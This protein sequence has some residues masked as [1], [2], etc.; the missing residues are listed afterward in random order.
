M[1]ELRNY[2]SEAIG[3]LYT[4]FENHDIGN[5]LLVLP[6]GGGKSLIAAK[7]CKDA[8]QW[9][10]QRV[11]LL[12]HVR[13]LIEQNYQALHSL[14]PE[15]PSGIYCA[16]LKRKQ[17]H[18][19]I[20][21]ASIQ[22]VHKK[23]ELIGWR[24]LIIIDECHLV[25]DTDGTMYRS[26]LEKMR[27]INP[28]VRIIGLSATP[29]RLKTGYL[30][31]GEDAIFTDI[32]FEL[33][34]IRLVNEGYLSPLIGKSAV[35]HV[36]TKDMA[37]IAGE[38][39]SKEMEERF[40][41]PALIAAAVKEIM[42]FGKDRK[43][44]L[45]FCVSI[46]HAKNVA[47]ALTAMEI[48]TESVSQETPMVD[49]DRILSDFKSGKLRA[50]T[51]VSVLTTGFDAPITDLLAILRS[52]MSP[53][54]FVQIAGRGMRLSHGKSNCLVLDFGENLLR[55]G[56]ITHIKPPNDK[57]RKKDDE[58]GV[59]CPTCR[60]VSPIGTERCECGEILK[61]KPCPSCKEISVSS[62]KECLACGHIFSIPREIN[63]RVK[64]SYAQVM[65][66]DPT[67]TEM[68]TWFDVLDTTFEIHTKLGSAESMKVSYRLNTTTVQEW[69]GFAHAK[70]YPKK[71]A[72]KWWMM[73]GGLAPVPATAQDALSRLEEIDGYRAAKILIRK[74]DGWNRVMQ[75]ELVKNDIPLSFADGN[76]GTYYIQHSR[77]QEFVNVQSKEYNDDEIPF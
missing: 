26:F 53:G 75:P 51:N 52:T 30:H 61:P 28:H 12:T 14:W 60:I 69:I 49:R 38:F 10:N 50:V 64:A 11:L 35:T 74:E 36:E 72:A 63:H 42:E 18:N 45:L 2:Q 22:S 7:I 40:D 20:T 57:K 9:P 46:K 1:I 70:E 54:L 21:F 27:E 66:N 67:I 73:R 77:P 59:I 6:T 8:L 47:E 58:E 76:M 4:W 17:A 41:E 33:P 39:S 55:H 32:A 23:A 25:G 71:L 29:Y 44:W 16:A 62:A 31:K 5:P 56:P 13:E 3:A 34:I 37:L 15:A 65:S 24:D 43:A 68:P 19:P 48:A